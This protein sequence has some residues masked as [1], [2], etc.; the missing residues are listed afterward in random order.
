M[1]KCDTYITKVEKTKHGKLLWFLTLLLRGYIFC[2]HSHFVGR[3]KKESK[4]IQWTEDCLLLDAKKNWKFRLHQTKKTSVWYLNCSYFLSWYCGNV[5]NYANS[6]KANNM[7]K[8]LKGHLCVL[9]SQNK[10]R[11]STNE[12]KCLTVRNYWVF[13]SRKVSG[14]KLLQISHFPKL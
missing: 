3:I 6:T 14:N 8:Q 11:E 12:K 4:Y 2:S 5:E 10:W 9:R 7:K 1:L 13:L